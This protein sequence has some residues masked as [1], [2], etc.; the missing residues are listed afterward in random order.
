MGITVADDLGLEVQRYTD[1]SAFLCCDNPHC[2]RAWVTRDGV[3]AWE[4]VDDRPRGSHFT[5]RILVGCSEACLAAA[6]ETMRRAVR[7]S[8]PMPAGEWLDGLRASLEMDP[9]T[10]PIGELS[11]R[12]F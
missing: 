3:I 6:L 12:P 8:D 4:Q 10:T 9:A 5:S 7:W 2:E 11:S 1:P